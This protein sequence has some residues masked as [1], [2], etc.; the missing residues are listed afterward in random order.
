MLVVSVSFERLYVQIYFIVEDN[1]MASF[2]ILVKLFLGGG[3]CYLI[4]KC[5]LMDHVL[6]NMLR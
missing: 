4:I 2:H 5:I 6:L 3:E 1:T